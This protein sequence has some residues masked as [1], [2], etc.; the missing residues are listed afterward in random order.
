M[1]APVSEKASLSHEER[2]A[3]EPRAEGLHPVTVDRIHTAN[4]RIRTFKLGTKDK[5]GIDFK[6]GQW[7]DV[8]VP[9]IE[10]AGGFTITS[11]PR[12]A[13]PRL[14]ESKPYLELA[15]QKSP[16]NPPAAWL[17]K[18]E[19]DIKGK[20]LNVR[21]GGSF[22]FPPPDIDLADIKRVVLIAGGVGIN[23]LISILSH[24]REEHPS[25]RVHFLYS[26][27]LPR[28]N[29][30]PAEVLFLPRILHILEM[31]DEGSLA[32][33]LFFTGSGDGLVLALDDAFVASLTRGNSVRFCTHRID[34][35]ALARAVGDMDERKSSVYYV[36][37]PPVMTDDLVDHIR[38]QDQVSPGYVSCEKWW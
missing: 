38:G 3:E 31:A 5:N 6:A 15:I 37:G 11:S 19:E 2:T 24:I 4:D 35:A 12:H 16:D 18:P 1:P 34:E 25:L 29:P 14:A 27:K 33:D 36:C 21:V 28:T 30:N 23:P 10:K 13:A 22:V 17:W 7:L 26:T 8:H 32:L 9:G 20:E